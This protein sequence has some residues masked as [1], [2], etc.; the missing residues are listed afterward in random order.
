MADAA[1]TGNRALRILMW[2][3]IKM[4]LS[5]HALSSRLDAR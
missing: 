2:A 1:G 3:E 4:S 5:R